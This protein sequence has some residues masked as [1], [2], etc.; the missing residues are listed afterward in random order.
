[1]TASLSA[2]GD[3]AQVRYKGFAPGILLRAFDGRTLALSE[4]PPILRTLLVTDGTVTQCLEAY[5]WEPVAV[6]PLYQKEAE[7]SHDI[8]LLG[9]RAGELLMHRRVNL[10]GR[11]SERLYARCLS[12]VRPSLIPPA[13]RNRLIAGELG[14]GE[15]IRDHH[16]ESY[17]E[18]LQIGFTADWAE[19]C[20]PSMAADEIYRTYLIRLRGQ[21]AILVTES[22]SPSRM[23]L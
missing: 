22:F 13:L 16:F 3:C 9:A 18:L 1:M 10:Q 14:I 15:L 4:L 17:R 8:P 23:R 2:D 19:L 7:A 11:T 20:E 12:I 21:P 5:F 6:T